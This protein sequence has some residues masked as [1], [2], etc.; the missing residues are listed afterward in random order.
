MFLENSMN[1]FQTHVMPGYIKF[2]LGC[3]LIISFASCGNLKQLQYLQGEIDTVALRNI[4]FIE[5]VIQPGDLV[6]ITVYSDNQSASAVYNQG[7][8]TSGAASGAGVGPG[9]YL[10]SEDGYIQLYELGRVKVEGFSKKQVSDFMVQQYIQ[11][12]VLKNPYVEVRFL[13]FKVTVIGDVASPGIKTFTTDKV[14]IFDAISSSGD[15]S[16]LAKRSNVLVV[17]EIG[18]TRQF[19]RLDLTNPTVFNSP[20]YYLRQNDMIIVDPTKLKA[21][22]NDQLYRNIS[23][24]ASLLSIAVVIY[25]LFK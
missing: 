3:C 19:A 10:V 5:P 11:K 17:R 24:G 4:N 7:G 16:A 1:K 14:S 15:L 18:D 25:S 20:F 13:N 8:S 22:Q 2:I 6:S 9:G 12:N 23:I 21:R